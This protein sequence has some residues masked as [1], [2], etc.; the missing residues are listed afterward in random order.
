[1]G[2][3]YR[4]STYNGFKYFVTIVDDYSRGVWTFLLSS[5]SNAF[6]VLKNFLAMVERQF[7]VR[8]QVIR[9]D[10][11]FELGKGS[12]ESTFL[13]SEGIIH[14]MSC[15]TTP[16][17]NGIVERKYKHLLEIAKDVPV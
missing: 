3:S 7:D 12:Q 13:E 6:P 11:A 8:V 5:K 4:S 16:Q 17:Q 15:T 14:Q 10:N 2:W 1:M 9:S